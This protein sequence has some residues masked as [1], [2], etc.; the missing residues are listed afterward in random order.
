M[1]V[2]KRERGGVR[3]VSSLFVSVEVLHQNWP[4]N[5]MLSVTDANGQRLAFMIW[6]RT[7]VMI[8]LDDDVPRSPSVATWMPKPW[9]G[10]HVIVAA[11]QAMN[12]PPPAVR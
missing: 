6:P 9:H 3:V 1:W 7:T 8:A 11:E 4:A 2:A 10:L 5:G 12:D